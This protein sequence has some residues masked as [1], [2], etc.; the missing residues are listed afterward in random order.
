MPSRVG[1]QKPRRSVRDE[2]SSA[3]DASS[4]PAAM[5]PETKPGVPS[6][7]DM[8]GPGYG[9]ARA[10][11]QAMTPAQR[12]DWSMQQPPNALM[13]QA[14]QMYGQMPQ[15]T[16]NAMQGLG[17]QMAPGMGRG[18][19]PQIPGGRTGDEANF[20]P[21]VGAFAPDP[22]FAGAPQGGQSG[23]SMPTRPG[24]GAPPPGGPGDWG[25]PG[26]PNPNLQAIQGQAQAMQGAM[27]QMQGMQGAPAPQ[28]S[29]ASQLAGMYKQQDDQQAQAQGGLRGGMAS[30]PPQAAAAPIDP[31]Q[32]QAMAQS[33]RS[34]L[35]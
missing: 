20:G 14:A 23:M 21:G 22:G 9:A 3:F 29:E 17:Q 34:P 19:P 8:Y 28:L 35:R 1:M 32:R 12:L 5:K 24:P 10:A 6:P 7:G 33:L 16:R 26:T 4:A 30:P 11:Q 18:M 27:G 2:L 25:G 15:Q 13:H 31:M